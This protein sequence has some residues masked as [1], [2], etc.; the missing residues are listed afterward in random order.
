MK[1]ILSILLAAI[2]VTAVGFPVSAKTTAKPKKAPAVVKKIGYVKKVYDK[3][4]KRYLTID[5]VDIYFGS[6]AIKEA[7][8]DGNAEKDENGNY[9]VYDDYYMRNSSTKLSTYEISKTANIYMCNFNAMNSTMNQ[10]ITYDQF[11]KAISTGKMTSPFY[12]SPRM[13]YYVYLQG[14]TIIKIEQQY[15]P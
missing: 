4:G 3:S 13:P 6:Q 5:F 14:N 2:V 15:L 12:G 9:F 1:K 7:V 11:K 10:K 8:K